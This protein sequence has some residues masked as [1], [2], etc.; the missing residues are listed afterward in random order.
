MFRLALALALLVAVPAG[1]LELR[2][3]G[4]VFQ[5]EVAQTPE[6]RSRGLMGRARVP[7]RG[8]MLFAYP[9]E[10]FRAFWM[11]NCLTDLDLAYL[12]GAR[13]VV[14]IHRLRREPLRRPGETESAYEA[15]LPVYPSA[16]PARYALELAPGTLERLGVGVGDRVEF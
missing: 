2:L 10:E 15:R 4:E 14:S 1:A 13:R 12:D 7:P 9:E 8:G 6:A 3:A 11:K 5:V 16:A